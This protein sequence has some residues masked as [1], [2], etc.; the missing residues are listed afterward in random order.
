MLCGTCWKNNYLCA[1]HPIIIVNIDGADVYRWKLLFISAVT[2]YRSKIG[3]CTTFSPQIERIHTRA[4][5][6][7]NTRIGIN[8]LCTY[9]VQY[10]RNITIDDER[11]SLSAA[12]HLDCNVNAL[13]YMF[14][15]VVHTSA[16]ILWFT[17]FLV[18][19]INDYS[20]M[21]V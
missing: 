15:S 13:I 10:I 6:S 4:C 1:V 12:I 16:Y 19:S 14:L 2:D 3:R 11:V 7:T 21:L 5:T 20:C 8:R 18:V 17:D 9:N